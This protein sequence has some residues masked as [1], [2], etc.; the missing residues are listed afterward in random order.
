MKLLFRNVAKTSRRV[1]DVRRKREPVKREINADTGDDRLVS[2]VG[3][4]FAE[5]SRDFLVG[6]VYI[7]YPLYSGGSRVR[8]LV[9]R[10]AERI[11]HFCGN[12][13]VGRV[14]FSAEK[15]THIKSG[16]RGRIEGFSRSSPAGKLSFG[17]DCA[18]VLQE[19]PSVFY[20]V[21]RRIDR[22]EKYE[23]SPETFRFE[24]ILPATPESIQAQV[25]RITF[26][27]DIM[28]QVEKGS[29][30]LREVLSDYYTSPA[31]KRDFAADEAGLLPKDL[32]RG[33]LSEDGIYNLL[34]A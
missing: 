21:V 28:Q 23:V 25:R 2:A 31:W 30:E 33:V 29:T 8:E 34:E 4:L 16:F 12:E 9:Y 13:G 1:F 3:N 26:Y 10:L 32:T 18:A 6:N 15:E 11:A 14:F 17:N 27:E 19:L 24:K 5:D 20:V 7:V 22:I